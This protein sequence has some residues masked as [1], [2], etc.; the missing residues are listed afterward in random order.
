MRSTRRAATTALGILGILCTPAAAAAQA[1]PALDQPV[2]RIA[3]VTP[4]AIQGV[5]LDEHGK[6]VVG[7]MVSALGTTTKFAVTDRL[8][9]FE[10][11]TLSPGPYLVRAHLSG[12][13]A[14][15]GQIV[16]VRSSSRVS[17]SIALRRIGSEDNLPVLAAGI[18]GAGT[19]APTPAV[20]DPADK[21]DHGETA[22]RIR[23]ARRG[24]LKDTLTPDAVPADGP[25]P[26][27]SIF[28]PMTGFG[29]AVASP[30]RVASALFAA[31]LSGQVNF[32]TIGSLDSPQ[33]LVAP[34]SLS[35]GVAYVAVGAPVGSRAD[36]SMRA[37]L[38]QGD[39][40]S[41]SI[42][43]AYVNRASDPHHY[44]LG[45]SYA[46][47]RYDG[48]NPALRV[49][50]ASRTA[51]T[52]YGFDTWTID[53]ALSVTYGARYS[54]YDYLDGRG[55]LSP[56]AT[57]TLL[58]GRRTRVN[59]MVSSLAVAPGAEEFLAPADGDIW[60]PPQ[61]TFS[62]LAGDQPLAPERTNYGGLSIEHDFH[63]STVSVGA[64]RQQ[65]TNQIVTMFGLD[66]PSQLEPADH[67]FVANSGD[68][69]VLGWTA[70]WHGAIAD[71]VHGSVTYSDSRADWTRAA[72]AA[73][74]VMVAPS[75]LRTEPERIHDVTASVETAVPET[76][77]RVL[78]LYR[79]SN[80][81]ASRDLQAPGLDSRFD[82]QVRQALPFMNFSNAQW[83]MLVAVRNFYRET[84]LDDSIYDELLVVHPPKR[85]VGG[86][87]LRF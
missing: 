33:Q 82:V 86:L 74:M 48:A 14:S 49:M 35:R 26:D 20:G 25:T 19:D 75:A 21:D 46:A 85:I 45:L 43:G 71:R 76:S 50:E 4:G 3:S 6:P 80:A 5:V 30:A 56:R 78:V 10:L 37:A 87:T 55:L 8:G 24:V 23:H 52:L 9:R 59:A 58:P 39:M 66:L 60:L 54:Y 12:Y 61:R 44:E 18:G 41:W 2:S 11:R 7:A 13:V 70:S 84:G 22:W 15:R 53:R 69:D 57:V 72:D 42:A 83:E 38:T 27:Q 28:G 62:S 63:G 51:G 81:F 65:V 34:D 40:A 67:Y 1:V 29:R 32:L 77:T 17:S 16:E 31:P 36:W 73:Y 64:F 79:V 47:Q 68:V